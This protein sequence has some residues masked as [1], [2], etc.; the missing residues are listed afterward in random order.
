MPIPAVAVRELIYDAN[1]QIVK[2]PQAGQAPPDA[3]V[4]DRRVGRGAQARPDAQGNRRRVRR[5]RRQGRVPPDQDGHRRRQVLRGLS[6]LK[7]GDQVI[8]GP[9]NSVR[10]MADGDR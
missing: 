8:T 6:G 9:Y 1:G 10:G 5:A 4:G 7:P 3:D 2:E